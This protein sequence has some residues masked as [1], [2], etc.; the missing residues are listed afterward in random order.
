M[1][2]PQ[3]AAPLLQ[4]GRELER[5]RY[6]EAVSRAVEKLVHLLKSARLKVSSSEETFEK[7]FLLPG[8]TFEGRIDLLLE[9]PEGNKVIWDLKWSTRAKY[10]REEL[11]GGKA[12]QL[13]A[14]AWLLA[15]ADGTFPPAG[16]FML[17]QGELL[18]VSCKGIPD[19]CQFQ[20]VDLKNVW[21]GGVAAYRRRN[22][23]LE[24]GIVVAAAILPEEDEDQDEEGSD[25]V[26]ELEPN[27][28]WCE[29]VNLCGAESLPDGK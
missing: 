10:K 2:V 6:R 16:Y 11:E 20:E 14:Y 21:E 9:S 27:C 25:A 19:H 4:P 3:M 13:A 12:L 24:Q 22:N 23:E 17:S 26:L 29:Y 8:K 28:R 18:S 15:G 5:E 1:M 7:E